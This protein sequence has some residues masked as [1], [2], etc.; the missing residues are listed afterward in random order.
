MTVLA[1]DCL[2]V[3]PTFP[4]AMKEGF[5]FTGI[6]REAEYCDIALARLAAAEPDQ[7]GLFL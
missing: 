7:R 6:E 5:A 1:G 4:A 3:L 2:D